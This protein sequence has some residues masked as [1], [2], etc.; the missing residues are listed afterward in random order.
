MSKLNGKDEITICVLAGD[1]KINAF[2]DSCDLTDNHTKMYVTPTHY[3]ATRED[4]Y[5]AKNVVSKFKEAHE[6]AGM[7][8][9]AVFIVGDPNSAYIN[10]SVKTISS[11]EQWCVLDEFLKMEGASHAND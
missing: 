1:A 6:K 8:V 5:N 10:P 9:A 3:T 2:M 11:G 7:V 4:N